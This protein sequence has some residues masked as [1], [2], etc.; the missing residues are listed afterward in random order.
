MGVM[1]PNLPRSGNYLE[2]MYDDKLNEEQ[3]GVQNVTIEEL[4]D[5]YGS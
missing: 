2:D 1:I 5:E 3:K 4:V